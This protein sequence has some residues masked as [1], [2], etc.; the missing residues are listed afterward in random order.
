MI[1]YVEI[2]ATKQ[3]RTAIDRALCLSFPVCVT[4]APGMGKSAALKY[5][6]EKHDYR[7]VEINQTV[8][9]ASNLYR[10]L[11][12]AYSGYLC[13]QQYLYQIRRALRQAV[14]PNWS[15]TRPRL[16]VVDEFQTLSVTLQRELLS[17]QEGFNIPLILS[18][19]P[20]RLART[21][22]DKMAYE[23]IRSRVGPVI[24]IYPPAKED[25][26][27]LG[28]AYKVEGMDAY[29]DLVTFG[30]GKTVREIC[31]LLDEAI[32]LRDGNSVQLRHLEMAA[33][34]LRLPFPSIQNSKNQPRKGKMA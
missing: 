8:N 33:R 24:E 15:K 3:V 9:S 13:E 29:R 34:S 32:R 14:A 18:G 16:L 12:E 22:A 1:S 5:E 20:E 11:F 25:C 6:C 27:R 7:Y 2:G 23:Q 28:A 17:I 30:S 26:E 31:R 4:S 19:N 10:T 21:K